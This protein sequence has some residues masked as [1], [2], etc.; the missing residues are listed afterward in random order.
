MKRPTVSSGRKVRGSRAN[1]Y[2]YG[3]KVEWARALYVLQTQLGLKVHPGGKTPLELKGYT[4]YLPSGKRKIF[5]YG[6][7][8]LV[9]PTWFK[10]PPNIIKPS[11]VDGGRATNVSHITQRFIFPGRI[12]SYRLRKIF[13][14]IHLSRRRKARNTV[15]MILS[16][17]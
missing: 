11:A 8:G 5:L 6:T 4:H 9:L 17:L 1:S 7:Q 10:C 16:S 2:F 3:D 14:L 13:V 15:Q 12:N